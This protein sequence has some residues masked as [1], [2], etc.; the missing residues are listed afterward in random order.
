MDPALKQL[1]REGPPD[2][3]V[4]AIIRQDP[5]MR[6]V[7]PQVTVMAEF[8]DIKTVRVKRRDIEAVWAHP[9]TASVK[10]AR[11]L[12]FE[13]P[14]LLNSEIFHS[15]PHP[16]GPARPYIKPGGKG[17]VL[18]II[19]WGIDFA[20]PAFRDMEG[21][22]RI[23]AI[24][25]QRG[26]QNYRSPRYG[27]GRVFSKADI[28]NALS[29]DNP[30]KTL[31]Y[32][33]GDADTGIG[34]HGTH[35]ADI[36][37]GT[38]YPGGGS[39]MAPHASLAFVH[40]ATSKLSGLGSLGDASRLLEAIDYLSKLAGDRPL[41][42][43][44]SVG[45][46]GGPHCGL[47]LCEQAFDRFLEA[48]NNRMIIQSAG[49]YFLSNTHAQGILAP[50]KKETLKWH[51]NPGDRT[52]NELEVWYSDRDNFGIEVFPP[53]A[54]EPLIVERGDSRGL[55]DAEGQEI[56]R[57]YHRA[58]D[59]NSPD[60]N[61]QAFLR[62][63]A[64]AGVWR[65]RLSGD[66]IEDGRYH[67]WIERDGRGRRQSRFDKS[68]ANP[69]SSIG[70]ICNGFLTI[71]VGAAEQTPLG[72]RPAKFA[73]SGPT[74]DGRLKPDLCAPGVRIAAARSTPKWASAPGKGQTRMSGASQAAPYV[75][76]IAASMISA[77]SSPKTIHQLRAQL[78]EMV[79]PVIG[80]DQA[81]LGRGLIDPQL[82]TVTATDQNERIR[83]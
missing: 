8:A 19:D 49:N 81:R 32:H 14:Q 31:G 9:G 79:R 15:S 56:G 51:I 6:I 29:S 61:F 16:S 34:A 66:Q 40:L 24:W 5:R 21:N 44:L 38:H 72:I 80:G 59:P 73:S 30:Y 10:A 3:I 52:A 70:S 54:T 65:I 2:E 23:E 71:A 48:R 22:S 45:R 50:G 63:A 37:G 69:A 58:Y 57:L 76:G 55:Y 27:Y 33:P 13:D 26:D 62:A 25:D 28:D 4:E 53:G 17:V 39:G 20:H 64:P 35:V 41:V 75:A 67:A 18:G 83:S 77:N 46:H 43:N 60:H 82:F 7:P 11:I 42:I 12:Q 68:C 1:I 47:S 36:A 74:R 78:F